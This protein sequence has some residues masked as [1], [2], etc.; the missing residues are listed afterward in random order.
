MMMVEE[1]LASG[2][3]VAPFGFVRDGSGYFLLSARSTEESRKCRVF[4][5]WLELQAQ[6]SVAQG[7]EGTSATPL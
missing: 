1:E 7:L 4:R 3:L 6:A 5:Q 2:Q